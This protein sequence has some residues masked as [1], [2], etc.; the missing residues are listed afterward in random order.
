MYIVEKDPK[1]WYQ[2]E[3]PAYIATVLFDFVAR[4]NDELSVNAGQKI[5]LAPQSLQP[6]NLP[7]WCKAT[8]NVNIGLIPCNYVRVIG[9]LKK[10]K[11]N[12][13]VASLNEEKSSANENHYRNNKENF[14]NET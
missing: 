12:A 6:T 3:E 4:N 11:E 13:E 9:Q 5:C 14:A 10:R 8:N 2:C 7:G 1:E